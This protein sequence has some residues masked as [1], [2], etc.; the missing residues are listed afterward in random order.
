MT[1]DRRS[2]QELIRYKLSYEYDSDDKGGLAKEDKGTRKYSDAMRKKGFEVSTE[3]V[4][5]F[6]HPQLPY[7]SCSPD[8]LVEL[9]KGP[10]PHD[11]DP[12][13]IRAPLSADRSSGR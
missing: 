11:V 8:R 6:V 1:K 13:S 7:I 2:L 10:I 4:G 5:M 3:V 9:K 12:M